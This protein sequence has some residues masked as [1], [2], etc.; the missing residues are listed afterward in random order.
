MERAAA[1]SVRVL[2]VHV[3]SGIPKNVDNLE[4]QYKMLCGV[5][6]TVHLGTSAYAVNF[7]SPRHLSNL[8]RFL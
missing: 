6:I 1:E 5:I 2:V 7:I 8:G 4:N 3:I